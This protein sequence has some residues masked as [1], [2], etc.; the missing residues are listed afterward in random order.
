MTLF[1]L[2]AKLGGQTTGL[3]GKLKNNM[4]RDHIAGILVVE[5]GSSDF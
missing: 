5:T 1:S 3:H 4:I 2:S